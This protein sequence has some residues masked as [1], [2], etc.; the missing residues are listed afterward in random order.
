[1][2][3]VLF[4]QGAIGHE[5]L[6]AS[7]QD[8]IYKLLHNPTHSGLHLEQLGNGHIFSA[9]ISGKSRLIFTSYVV[10]GRS[11]LLVLDLLPNHEYD[12]CK[13]LQR[14][15]MRDYL[16]KHHPEL[17]AASLSA[18]PI[19]TLPDPF[20]IDEKPS[21]D[22]PW[23]YQAVSL[24]HERLV[25]F[26]EAQQQAIC[27]QYPLLLS[28]MAGSGKSS[29]LFSLIIQA[30][31]KGSVQD[32]KHLYYIAHSARLAKTAK[33]ELVKMLQ[34]EGV[35]IT[36]VLENYIRTDLGLIYCFDQSKMNQE[37]VPDNKYPL[38][39]SEVLALIQTQPLYKSIAKTKQDKIYHALTILNAIPGDI[40]QREQ[41]FLKL[42]TRQLPEFNHTERK[43]LIA[44]NQALQK[45][46]GSNYAI[47]LQDI[48]NCSVACDG[49]FIDEAHQQEL[50]TLRN[51]RIVCEN[52]LVLSMDSNQD[53][54][55]E[56]SI[57]AL[58]L[59]FDELSNGGL[60]HIVLNKSYR[61]DQVI[62]DVANLFLKFK[63]NIAKGLVDSFEASEM[64]TTSCKP[65]YC[66]LL[67]EK[68][69]KQQ[70]NL[71]DDWALEDGAA[72]PVI[73]FDEA[74]QVD[75]HTK[76]KT[77]FV[78]QP[79]E[80]LSLD[81]SSVI[82]YLSENN[83][84]VRF[85]ERYC[86]QH[87]I[88]LVEL[89]DYI[90]RGE[91][92]L[93]P[94]QVI[95]AV[96]FLRALHV[97]VTRAKHR[98][99][100]YINVPQKKNHLIRDLLELY[101]LKGQPSVQVKEST[102]DVDGLTKEQKQQALKKIY[103]E[104]AKRQLREENLSQVRA[105]LSKQCQLTA[106]EIERWLQSE[107]GQLNGVA[108]AKSIISSEK[109]GQ[110]AQQPQ[111]SQALSTHKKEQLQQ[112]TQ[113]ERVEQSSKVESQPEP[114]KPKTLQYLNKF[115]LEPSAKNVKSLLE[116]PK[117]ANW[118]FLTPMANG[119]SLFFNLAYDLE[120]RAKFSSLLFSKSYFKK[121]FFTAM[122]QALLSDTVELRNSILFGLSLLAP[123]RWKEES[124]LIK[125]QM[126][127]FVKDVITFLAALPTIAPD[128]FRWQLKNKLSHP[129]SEYIADNP[130]TLSSWGAGVHFNVNFIHFVLVNGCGS[131]ESTK[132]LFGQ[133][134]QII[135]LIE[136]EHLYCELPLLAGN[137]IFCL[138]S[139][140]EDLDAILST[141]V[142]V[143]PTLLEDFSLNRLFEV[144][145]ESISNQSA[146]EHLA[147]SK[148][149]Q[150]VLLKIFETTPSLA[151]NFPIALFPPSYFQHQ[152]S[153]FESLIQTPVGRAVFHKIALEV[154]NV[155]EF[156]LSRGA[157]LSEEIISKLRL[158][159]ELFH[160][161]P[162]NKITCLGEPYVELVN[163]DR[164]QSNGQLALVDPSQVVTEGEAVSLNEPQFKKPKQPTEQALIKK[165][166]KE[167]KTLQA[168]GAWFG[169]FFTLNQW[170]KH[171]KPTSVL[172]IL[173]H[174][175]NNKSYMGYRNRSFEVCQGLGWLIETDEGEIELKSTEVPTVVQ[176]AFEAL[177]LFQDCTVAF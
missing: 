44:L 167:Y 94:Q 103:F 164:D 90:N 70:A 79:E 163:S 144:P 8:V 41:V 150:K 32:K 83:R 126:K 51:L 122:K 136:K 155:F 133:R 131:P 6:L 42:G 112:A 76:L 53:L 171:N 106:V 98:I 161:S 46:L 35:T 3:K 142:E 65:G 50:S 5:G 101:I 160:V 23:S 117:A 9:R 87:Q 96:M 57:R 174:A 135:D 82:I 175:I 134:G 56:G 10:N 38:N 111:E 30:L 64:E 69:I 81:Y 86:Q 2:A 45:A 100:F 110:V 75:V 153:L 48:E 165:F 13:F 95:D 72:V 54:T 115:F 4:W 20:K 173:E 146:I 61:N 104:E 137:S 151:K 88:S 60:S 14:K 28:G 132:R 89:K 139:A 107:E 19:K 121:L 11:Y 172:A 40:S 52:K 39:K 67:S 17:T 159:P 77:D 43:I 97:A 156:G 141:L 168:K 47:V 158:S 169:Q 154:P 36:K 91:L 63:R 66:Q 92:H 74:E 7:Q 73:A 130:N 84:H 68:N 22:E 140:I 114:I 152:P 21:L 102:T 119:Y 27:T 55:H 93:L 16:A 170:S 108:T 148:S 128:N 25:I 15:V 58:L 59:H 113:S 62:C 120:L 78:L 24:M 129:C 145:P 127:S 138:L 143:K 29:V 18:T 124:L 26:N 80:A 109:G 33:A 147:H 49:I 105:I 1:M 149:G 85:L 31:K 176:E 34:A 162:Q 166:Y 157:L 12:K 37:F 71:I 99:A 123:T 177:K 125:Q 118:L 116:H